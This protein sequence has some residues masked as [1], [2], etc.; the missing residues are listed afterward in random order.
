M[1]TLTSKSGRTITLR[2]PQEGDTQIMLDY[3]NA[4]GR[5]DIYLNVN[6][7]DLYNLIQRLQFSTT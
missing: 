5:E 3:V 7:D 1:Y 4:L 2:P 6:P